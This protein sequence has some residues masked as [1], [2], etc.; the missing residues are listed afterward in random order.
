MR[1]QS[2]NVALRLM[3]YRRLATRAGPAVLHV[4]IALAAQSLHAETETSKLDPS[5]TVVRFEIRHMLGK[6]VGNFHG[7]RGTLRMDRVH[8]ENSSIVATV[9]SRTIETGNRTRDTHLRTELFE[10]AKY[11]EIMFRSR[12]VTRVAP[13]RADVLGD[14]TIHGIT[15]PFLLHVVLLHSDTDGRARWHIIAGTLKRS[16]FGLRWSKGVEAVSMIGDDVSVQIDAESGAENK[17]ADGD[18]R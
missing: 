15:K 8:P 9:E 16:D 2:W 1:K 11:L 7:V 4:A 5:K 13:D 18:G 14:L 10:S 6:V 3:S 17:R 12:S